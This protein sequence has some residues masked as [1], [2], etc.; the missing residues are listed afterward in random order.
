MRELLFRGKQAFNDKWAYSEYPFGTINCG[1][2]THDFLA[3][4]VGQFIG[5]TDQNGNKIFEGDIIS[6]ERVNALGYTTARV[7]E[8]KYYSE[9]PIFYVLATTGDAWD[10]VECKNI[11]VIGN[12]HDN[13]EL[14]EGV[15]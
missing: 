7:G 8:V 2:V 15:R 12:I 4:T 14:L 9:L 3:E 5:L 1:V 6:F 10:W 13:P 11:K